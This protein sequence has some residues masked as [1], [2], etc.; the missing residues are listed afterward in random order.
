MSIEGCNVNLSDSMPED[1]RN[2]A[3]AAAAAGGTAF[4]PASPNPFLLSILSIVQEPVSAFWRVLRSTAGVIG[5]WVV[6]GTMGWGLQAHNNYKL[7]ACPEPCLALPRHLGCSP[8]LSPL[9][10]DPGGGGQ[11]GQEEGRLLSRR[12]E[13]WVGKCCTVHAVRAVALACLPT[14]P[15]GNGSTQRLLLVALFLL[16]CSMF[17]TLDV[18]GGKKGKKDGATAGSKE[19]FFTAESQA[20]DLTSP[21]GARTPAACTAARITLCTLFSSS[22]CGR[23]L[24]KAQ[25]RHRTWCYPAPHPT[26]SFAGKYVLDLAHPAS[27]II[28]RHLLDLKATVGSR[29]LSLSLCC[30]PWKSLPLGRL[31]LS[32]RHNKRA[33]CS[34]PPSWP[35]QRKLKSPNAAVPPPHALPSP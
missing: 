19:Y 13:G 26:S 24:L 31:L 21:S 35:T 8:S 27:A 30:K 14:S 18:T 4:D 20:I 3:A 6:L 15:S 1:T 25:S 10:C 11:E 28:V 34:Q 33:S 16:A 12:Q 17:N 29:P 32:A 22:P 5:C 2:A 7:V 9:L 23:S